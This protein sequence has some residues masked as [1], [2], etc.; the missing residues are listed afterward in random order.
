MKDQERFVVVYKENLGFSGQVRILAD[1]LTGVQYV[2]TQSGYSG[3]MTV[4]V[5]ADGRPLLHSPEPHDR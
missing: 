1:K 2:Y 5:D 4:L 3:G